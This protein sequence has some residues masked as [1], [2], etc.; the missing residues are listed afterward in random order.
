MRKLAITAGL[1][2]ALTACKKNKWDKAISD[3]EGFRDKMCA[4][5]DKACADDIHKQY[6][7]W[8]K[9][10]MGDMGKDEKPPDNIIE[11]AE[12]TEKEM[13]DC[14]NKLKGGGDDMAAP[15][16]PAAPAGEGAAPAAPAGGAAPAPAGEAPKTP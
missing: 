4:C 11:K 9:G 6:K 3:T 14:R 1:L 7:D 13:R 2:L 16:A 8:E 5:K 12:K 15:P 10:M